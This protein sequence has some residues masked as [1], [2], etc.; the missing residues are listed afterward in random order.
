MN[1]QVRC[2]YNKGFQAL[3][4]YKF[5]RVSIM[6][7]EDNA[8]VRRTL[9]DVLRQF[10]FERI[11]MCKNGQEAIENLKLLKQAKN[12]GPDLIVADLVMAP[13]NGLLLCRWCRSAKETPNRMV[14][15]IMLS[16]AAD[17]DYVGSARDLGATEFLAKPFSGE[18]V[19]KKL[20]EVIDFPR[21]FVMN[22]NYFGPDRRRKKEPP[23]GE[24]DR[25]EKAEEDCTVVYSAEKM[26]KP[27][28][29]SDVF[30]FKPNN[31]LQ[32]KCAGG[33]M[34]PGER[35]EMPTAVIEQAEQKLERAALDFTK[36][37]Q[38]YLGRL[39]DLCT[40]ALLE[41]GRRTQQFVEI[42]QVALELR[43]QGG[44][45]GYPLISTFGK[46]LFDS[47]REGCRE[48]DA[49]VEIVK[50]HV[51]AMRAVLREKISGDGGEVGKA[52]IAALREGIEKQEKARKAK[53]DELKEQAGG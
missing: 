21:Q 36:W 30:L 12:P 51:D 25:R 29:E 13:I 14:P 4:V 17:Q 52:L 37:A 15:F 9:E 10:G 35:G 22:Q 28:A 33:R 44:T 31:Y 16:G 18:T 39:S 8:F 53:N 48:D 40:Q 5:D 43:G 11:T 23:P 2:F 19:Y 24:T 20:L 26:T 6:V 42:N 47:S 50:A 32:E 7:C 49:Q 41:P 34:N 27:K 38:D 3:A 45:F 46:M 1:I